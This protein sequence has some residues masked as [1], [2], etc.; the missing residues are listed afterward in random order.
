MATPCLVEQLLNKEAPLWSRVVAICTLEH[1]PAASEYVPQL[2]LLGKDSSQ[3]ATLRA[4]VL[5]VLSAWKAVPESRELIYD[6]ASADEEILRAHAMYSIGRLRLQ[7]EHELLELGL[8]DTARWVAIEAATAWEQIEAEE[9][10]DAR[11][12]WYLQSLEPVL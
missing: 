1:W 5:R 2:R 10:R 6:F 4:L 7:T 8:Y 9:D 11:P 3:P 12:R